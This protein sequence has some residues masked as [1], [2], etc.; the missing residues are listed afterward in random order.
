MAATTSPSMTSTTWPLPALAP[1]PVVRLPGSPEI[2]I[3]CDHLLPS[4]SHKDRAYIAMINALPASPAGNLL[5]DYS[6][7]NGS[8]ALGWWAARVGS[9]SHAFLPAGLPQPRYTLTEELGTTVTITPREDFVRG[10][11]EAA[12]AFAEAHPEAILLNQSDNLANTGGCR[13]AG[14]EL[15]EQLTDEGVEPTEFVAGVGTGG[16]F[17]GIAGALREAFPSIRCTAVEVPEAPAIWAKRHGETF[18]SQFPSVLGLGAGLIAENTDENL[19]DDLI[20]VGRTDI[21]S[22]LLQLRHDHGLDVGPS[23]ALNV[24]AAR[25]IAADS[26]GVIVTLSFDRGNRYDSAD[27]FETGSGPDSE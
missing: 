22:T 23:T 11:R 27:L 19:I 2:I 1:T 3:K 17:S 15:V 21:E 18:E 13:Q 10:A 26:D 24:V 7:G 5:V 9:T 12:A 20:I 16:A 6:T 8:I 25:R 14:V 4:G